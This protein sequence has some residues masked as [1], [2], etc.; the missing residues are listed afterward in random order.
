MVSVLGIASKNRRLLVTSLIAFLSLL[1]IMYGKEQWYLLYIIIPFL[2]LFV[3]LYEEHIYKRITTI[4]LTILFL[5]NAASTIPF[6]INE[7][8]NNKSYA[9]FV[10]SIAQRVPKDSKILVSALPDPTFELWKQ[11]YTH[12]YAVPHVSDTGMLFTRLQE[13][14][15]LIINVVTNPELK[16][17]LN[18][19][20][21]VSETIQSGGY[22]TEV[23]NLR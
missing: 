1:G 23:I 17:I 16:K 19:S 12:V 8:K 11:N 4:F 14:D 7:Q 13:Y 20:D 21:Y 3:A 2:L 22:T 10:T 9:N 15:Y 5:L 18:T 6:M